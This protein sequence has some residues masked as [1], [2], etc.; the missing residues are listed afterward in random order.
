MVSVKTVWRVLNESYDTVL[1][2]GKLASVESPYPRSSVT[3]QGI[4]NV[5]TVGLPRISQFSPCLKPGVLSD[6]WLLISFLT[7]NFYS[8][9]CQFRCKYGFNF[10]F[11]LSVTA[12][13]CP[14]N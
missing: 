5:P 9:H 13:L 12:I 10:I 3:S 2:N 11:Q 4:Q 7:S 14:S 1:T 8:T 6:L